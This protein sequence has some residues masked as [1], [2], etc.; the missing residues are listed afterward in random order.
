MAAPNVVSIDVKKPLVAIHDYLESLFDTYDMTE[1][2]SA[3]REALTLEIAV[4]LEAEIRKVDSIAG[5]LGHCE[6]Q[7]DFASQ[8]IKRLQERKQS[9]ARKQARLE[10]YIQRVM[11][12]AGKSKLEG[13]TSTLQ[14][15][16]CPASV[17]V[18]N[19]DLVPQEFIRTSI[20]ESVDKTAAKAALKVGEVPG[21]KLIT[22]RQ[23]VIRK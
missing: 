13:R 5:Y 12:L 10:D 4:Y 8:E 14:L 21:L 23:S 16:S 22:D 15:K 2:G 11:T 7:Q 1:E 9:F 6:S 20:T 3:E 17:E 19:Q 18:I